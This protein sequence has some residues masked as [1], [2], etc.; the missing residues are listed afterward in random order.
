MKANV[1]SVCNIRRHKSFSAVD[2]PV[3]LLILLTVT[4]I[5]REIMCDIIVN[6]YRLR[7][8]PIALES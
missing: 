8:T 5:V 4:V 7:E 2:F 1:A 6:Y 3:P